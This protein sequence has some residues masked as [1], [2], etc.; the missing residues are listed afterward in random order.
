MQVPTPSATPGPNADWR[1]LADLR[2]TDDYGL[3]LQVG[4]ILITIVLIVVVVWTL[5]ARPWR[6]MAWDVVEAKLKLGGIGEVKVKP[7]HAT[8]QIAHR[9][10]VEIA[11]RKVGMAFEPENDVINEV[12]DSWYAFF[13]EMR[14]LAKSVPAHRLR[15]DPQTRRFVSVI[16]DTL[17]LGLRPHLTRWQAR[18]RRWYDEASKSHLDKSPQEIQ[19]LFPQYALLVQDL[20][21]VNEGLIEYRD[22]LH[23]IANGSAT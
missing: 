6:W 15:D 18:F 17:N 9:A 16:V 23:K 12:Y 14:S 10:W 8:V 7:N 3:S 20:E 19:R 11:T 5:R 13:R 22:W 4:P 21:E 1:K 2:I